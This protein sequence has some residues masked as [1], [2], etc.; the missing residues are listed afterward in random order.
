MAPISTGCLATTADSQREGAPFSSARN[1]SRSISAC[2][3]P[4]AFG[5]RLDPLPATE[6]HDAQLHPRGTECDSANLGQRGS[7][8]SRARPSNYSPRQPEANPVARVRVE[9]WVADLFSRAGFSVELTPASGDHGVDL[10]ASSDDHLI[11]VQCK[12]WDAPVGE[13]IVRDLY[14]SMMAAK[15]QFGCLITT[16]SVTL[17]AEQFAR[18]K[19]ICL[20]E[21]DA[22]IEVTRSPETLSQVIMRGVL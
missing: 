9:R 8:T 18:S 6:S 1:L 20:I 10:W 22:L 4:M 16:G 11:A 15:A 13:P 14:G 17:Q 7:T 12:R 5:P 3:F 2:F 19:P 21:F